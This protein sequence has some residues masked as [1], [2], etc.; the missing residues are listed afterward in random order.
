MNKLGTMINDI[1]MRRKI[2][3]LKTAEM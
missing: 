1:E 3:A 2:K